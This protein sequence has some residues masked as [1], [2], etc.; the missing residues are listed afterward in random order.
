MRLQLVDALAALSL[1]ALLGAGGVAW[2]ERVDDEA[3]E[4]YGASLR[5]LR[6]LDFRL[7]AE[8]LQA[9]SGGV[10]HY[11]GIARTVA[12][13]ARLEQQLRAAPSLPEPEARSLRE[14][15]AAAAAA[16]SDVRAQVERFK[17]ANAVL[18][19]S[20]RYLPLLAAEAA[21]LDVGSMV[22]DA[23]LMQSWDDPLIAERTQREL[24]DLALITT[25]A[26][27]SRSEASAGP[28]PKTARIPVS[29]VVTARAQA[30]SAAALLVHARTAFQLGPRVRDLTQQIVAFSSAER[31][32]RITALFERARQRGVEQEASRMQLL[33]ALAILA[34][35]LGASSV[36]LRLRSAAEVQRRTS[37][38]L[39][40]ALSAL[41]LEQEKQRELGELKTRF[42]A[43]TSHEFRTPLSVIMSSAEMLEAYLQRWP[44]EK[45]AEHFARIRSA[46][47]GMTRMLESIL[48]IGRSD[49]GALAFEPRPI[50]L[51][52][53][54][55]DVLSA[56][57]Q[58][59]P[60]AHRIVPALTR[61]AEWVM[62][63]DGLL[64]QVLENLLSNALKYSP[65]G[66]EIHYEVARDGAELVFRIRDRGM[67]IDPDD[68]K[69]LFETFQRGRNVGNIT[70][71]GLGLAVVGR[72]VKLHGGRISVHSELGVGSEFT[73]RV[74]YVR[75]CHEPP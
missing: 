47:L 44:E 74:P 59:H 57:R 66:G 8:V 42:V 52:H 30:D 1:S 61:E 33:F 37:A 62:A 4:R 9:R 51:Q 18:R 23:L 72:A 14:D 64:R 75:S 49:A 10:G 7:S 34:L 55:L 71:T 13:Q 12:A 56:V 53:F 22:Q 28:A 70:G 60:N 63:D 41:Q 40:E 20:L 19:N 35:L 6:A 11:D 2:S 67:G 16:R 50:E 24:A 46:A 26:A 43:M 27:G 3:V 73:V 5:A 21:P 29:G 39:T 65:A 31:M 58:A 25:E 48:M 36:I 54:C 17:S 38:Q 45:R 32:E 68:Q 15:L 69:H